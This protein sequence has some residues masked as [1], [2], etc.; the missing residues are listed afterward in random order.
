MCPADTDA[1][2]SKLA[3]FTIFTPNLPLAGKLYKTVTIHFEKTL[4]KRKKIKEVLVKRTFY[5]KNVYDYIWKDKETAN[6][7]IASTNDGR[8]RDYK[9]ERANK[10]VEISYRLKRFIKSQNFTKFIWLIIGAVIAILGKFI[11]DWLKN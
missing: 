4:R 9:F 5:S 7:I 11:Y 10:F 3:L 6:Q 8:K 2:A 1:K